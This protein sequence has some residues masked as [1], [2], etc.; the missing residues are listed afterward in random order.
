MKMQLSKPQWQIAQDAA[1]WRTAICGRRFGKTFLSI[2]ELCYAAR[3]PKQTVWYVAPTYKQAKQIVFRP[4]KERLMDLRW[5]KKIN[6]TN[7]EIELKNGSVIGLRGADNYDSLRGVGLNFLVLDEFA[8]IKPEA[9]YETLRP[10]LSDKAGRALFIGTPKGIGNWSYDIFNK[11]FED[12]DNW[13]SYQFTTLDGGNVPFTEVESAR[14]DLDEKTFNQ[15]YCAT[16]ETYSGVI[17]YNFDRKA[18]VKPYD[19]LLPDVIHVGIDFNIDPM[20]A[21]VGI[22]T[23][24]GFHFIDYLKVYGSN[25][26]EI[27]DEI[28]RRYPSKKIFVY[29]DAS[30]KQRRSSAN[31][32]TDH[33]ILQNAGFVVKS[34]NSNP[35]VKDR[36][37]AVNSKLKNTVGGIGLWVDPKCKSIIEGLER[38]T[39]KEGTQIPDKDGTD[40]QNDA[41]GY[42]ISWLYPIKR[43]RETQD[44]GTWRH[45]IGN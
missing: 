26:N 17:Y 44:V 7:L 11:G 30:G 32:M 6:E 16:F 34:G 8:D 5:V 31:G 43:N 19:G 1:R 23:D 36:I 33:I 2:R 20:S 37:A 40:H 22:Q 14:S 12:P 38:Q 13:S 42:V 25:T 27:C 28:K 39:Y 35:A 41:T 24:A 9:W 21:S 3:I 29:P 10:T 4:L 15:E 18:N 45:R